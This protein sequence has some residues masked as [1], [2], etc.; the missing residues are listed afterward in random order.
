MTLKNYKKHFISTL[1]THYPTTEVLSFFNLLAADILGFSRVDIVL[2]A[3][4][5]INDTNLKK[6]NQALS[7]LGNHKPL[8]YIL[9]ETEFYGLPFK[10]NEHTLIPRPETEELVSWILESV[11]NTQKKISILDIGTG[12]G[13]IAISLAK[14]LPNAQV[15]GYDISE[16]TLITATSNASLNNV[17]VDFKLVDILKIETLDTSFDI[18]VSNPPY[19][20]NL[21]KKEIQ[22]NVLEHE[23]HTALFVEDDDPLIFYTK[24]AN[25]AKNNLNPNGL[26]FFEINQYLGKE[27]VALVKSI[28]FNNVTLK[29]DIFKADRMICASRKK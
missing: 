12:S 18:I 1:E 4:S 24:I 20:R 6:L 7:E 22:K 11:E 9:G 13:C 21:E 10:V 19:V 25:L 23:P 5:E 8:Q 28:G 16:K 17:S 29:Q 2:E 15:T 26:L 14:N 27:T 3:A